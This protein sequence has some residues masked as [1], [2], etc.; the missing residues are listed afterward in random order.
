MGK[1]TADELQQALDAA[2]QMREAG[3]DPDFMAK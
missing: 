3:N 2:I 1:P